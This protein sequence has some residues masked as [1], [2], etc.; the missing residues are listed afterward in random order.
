MRGDFW[1]Y[2]RD[3]DYWRYLWDD[4]LSGEA[5]AG[6]TVMACVAAFFGG[7]WSSGQL[8]PDLEP[9]TLVKERLLTVTHKV[10]GK[11]ITR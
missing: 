2:W 9:V 8:S 7:L 3:P 1:R 4:R 11:T 5:K 10:D 6:L